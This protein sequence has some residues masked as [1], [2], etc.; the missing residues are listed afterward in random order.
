MSETTQGAAKTSWF[1]GLKAEWKKIIWPSKSTL[2]KESV[3]VA[4]I[5]V[6][7]GALISVIDVGMEHLLA[8][9]LKL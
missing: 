7:L 1:K 3:A 9:I 6:I 4:V 2:A 5:T 8:A